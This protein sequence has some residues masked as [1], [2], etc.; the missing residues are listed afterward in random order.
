MAYFHTIKAPTRIT[1]VNF[2]QFAMHIYQ[3]NVLT[4][5]SNSITDLMSRYQRVSV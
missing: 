4:L 3:R 2:L 5:Q 1:Q